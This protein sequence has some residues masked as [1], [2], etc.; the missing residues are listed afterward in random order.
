MLQ[1]NLFYHRLQLTS[2]W[3]KLPIWLECWQLPFFQYQEMCR[4]TFKCNFNVTTDY[5]I[6]GTV[7][8]NVTKHRDLGIV[9]SSNLSW[10][11]H[12]EAIVA[13]AYKSFGLL[14]RTFKHTFS[15]QTKR[16]LYLT[17]VRSKLL[18]C[19]PLWWP[20]LIKEFLLFERIQCRATKFIL[21]DYTMDYK[22]RLPR[23]NLLSL[24]YVLE[25]HDV[26]FL[27]KS[28][29]SPTGSFNIYNYVHLI[30]VILDLLAASYAISILTILF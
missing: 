28:L 26:L 11:D 25:L 13:K 5:S 8:T 23:L 18:Y 3:L 15:I 1:S 24:M 20:Y 29:K 21:N 6:N 4:I 30:T 12:I 14:R 17:L 16:T 7:L 10:V 9:F 19:S 22:T 27:I 2:K